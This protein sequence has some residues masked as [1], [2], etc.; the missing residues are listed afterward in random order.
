[1]KAYSAVEKVDLIRTSLTIDAYGNFQGVSRD[2]ERRGGRTA[3]AR[4]KERKLGTIDARCG[5]VGLEGPSTYRFRSSRYT[6]PTDTMSKSPLA[7]FT[8]T[9]PNFPQSI[10]FPFT[11]LWWIFLWNIR[12]CHFLCLFALLKSFQNVPN[13]IQVFKK[14]S[15]W[16]NLYFVFKAK[17]LF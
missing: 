16:A 7:P 3:P 1:M 4:K 11:I 17:T 10:I 2:P 8:F 5:N 14:F 13:L 9:P 12:F 15:N 6:C